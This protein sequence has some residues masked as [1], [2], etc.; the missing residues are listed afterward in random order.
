MS[1]PQLDTMQLRLRSAGP[2]VVGMAHLLPLPGSPRYGG[3]ARA[4]LEAARRDATTL[5]E[6]GVHAVMVENFGDVPFY[7]GAV[8]PEVVAQMSV[9]V[10]R[11]RDAV[12]GTMPIGVNVLR[13]DGLSALA[14]A[15]AAGA[16][17]IRVNVLC[18][19]RVA[20]QG[21]LQGIA[22]DLLRK[23]AALGALGVRVFADVDVKHSQPL[24]GRE[25]SLEDEVA[26]TLHRGL[27]DALIV[28]GSGTGRST[29]PDHVRRAKAAAGG[30]APVFVGSGVT[31]RTIDALLPHADGFIV[32]TALKRN[33][34]VEESV[35]V[36]RV[37]EMVARVG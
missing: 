36:G 8:P 23:R 15:Q 35:D 28:S 21:V 29:D 19:A 25:L 37:R 1:D 11:L 31:M 24:A 4:V 3:D 6:G 17:F 16:S 32:G 14:V 9:I 30:A 26:D 27:A 5:A 33:G 7:P 34:R 22:H 18:G 13:N 2:V 20:D 12:G 10:A